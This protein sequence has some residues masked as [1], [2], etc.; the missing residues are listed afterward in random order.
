MAELNNITPEEIQEADDI[1]VKVN[2]ENQ[3]VEILLKKNGV[4]LATDVIK[5]TESKIKRF[6]TGTDEGPIIQK[7]ED[8]Q[9]IKVEDF[10]YNTSSSTLYIV[11]AM[12]N[13]NF[14]IVKINQIFTGSEEPPVTMQNDKYNIGALWVNTSNNTVS[15][16]TAIAGEY[17]NWTTLQNKLNFVNLGKEVDLRNSLTNSV[18]ESPLASKEYVDNLINSATKREIVTELPEEDIDLN[19]IYM[20]RHEEGGEVFFEEHMYIDGEWVIIGNS[21]V[22]LTDYYTKSE[23]NNK[24]NTKIN[25]IDK[26]TSLSLQN[27]VWSSEILVTDY[28]Y[29]KLTS[30]GG[31]EKVSYQLYDKYN[32]LVNTG[33]ILNINSLIEISDISKIKFMQNTSMTAKTIKYQIFNNYHKNGD[34]GVIYQDLMIKG[35]NDKTYTQRQMLN[36]NE[37]SSHNYIY[38]NGLRDLIMTEVGNGNIGYLKIHKGSLDINFG[39]KLKINS[40]II[41]SS[42]G[43]KLFN[44]NNFIFGNYIKAED[45]NNIDPW[46]DI[47]NPAT[48]EYNFKDSVVFGSN[49]YGDGRNKLLLN[50]YIFGK[51]NKFLLDLNDNITFAGAHKKDGYVLGSDNT[52]NGKFDNFIIGMHNNVKGASTFLFGNNLIAEK[53][54]FTGQPQVIIGGFNKKV[55]SNVVFAV[56]AGVSNNDSDRKNVLELTK[57]G[58]LK[59]PGTLYSGSGA[60][61]W[62]YQLIYQG[63]PSE[64]IATVNLPINKDYDEY[65]IILGPKESGSIFTTTNCRLYTHVGSSYTS[66]GVGY[67]YLTTFTSGSITG[68]YTLQKIT[69]NL[70]YMTG[71][72]AHAGNK[73]FFT[74]TVDITGNEIKN[75]GITFETTE[76]SFNTNVGF[77]VYAR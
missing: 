55:N 77:K 70:F 47:N 48:K 42:E 29:V 1:E 61:K 12:T 17:L 46:Q 28:S 3:D 57:E 50:H 16:L 59:I 36:I 74:T 63:S 5:L 35:H 44:D 69:D 39:G 52:I 13:T 73:D 64:T 4:I 68:I 45:N 51:A 10:Y 67:P 54:N 11:N 9:N 72:H 76:G 37:D 24:L 27:N 18:V 20:I 75:N 25:K 8:Y 56:G 34:M 65:L 19:T 41:K 38:A 15:L 60:N 30:M 53:D 26:I 71:R 62:K 31:L 6:W 22:D 33:D 43:V 40:S 7:G 32:N 49:Q 66:N 23:V 2:Q 14:T 58:D 21:N